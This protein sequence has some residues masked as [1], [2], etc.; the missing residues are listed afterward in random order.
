MVRAL[1]SQQ[2]GRDSIPGLGF[3]CGLSLLLVLVFVQ[4]GFFRVLRFSLSS[5]TNASIFQFYLESAR[6]LV[7]CAKYIHKYTYLGDLYRKGGGGGGGNTSPLKTTAWEASE[8]LASVRSF[9]WIA[10]RRNSSNLRRYNK[11]DRYLVSK[12]Q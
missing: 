5:K 10:R 12:V 2:C 7:L 8:A 4:R 9:P 6:Q 1:A 3:I 11:H